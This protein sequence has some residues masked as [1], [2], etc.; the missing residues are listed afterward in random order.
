M[1]TKIFILTTLFSLF[2]IL[3]IQSDCA[4]ITTTQYV[5]LPPTKYPLLLK[6]D[7]PLLFQIADTNNNEGLDANEMRIFLDNFYQGSDKDYVVVNIF[8]FFKT[9]II[10]EI[11]LAQA[12]TRRADLVK[13]LNQLQICS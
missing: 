10:D 5:S 8:K 3:K 11:K 4:V 13:K 6:C 1:F 9:S 7:L 12:L 2:D